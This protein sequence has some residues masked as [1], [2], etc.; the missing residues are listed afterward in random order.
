MTCHQLVVLHEAG[1]CRNTSP[2]LLLGPPD[3]GQSAESRQEEDHRDDGEVD[4][5]DQELR[6][7]QQVQDIQLN[8][9]TARTGAA[10]TWV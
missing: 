1:F 4:P 9:T 6:E 2:D 3:G 5:V 8:R 7:G 10:L